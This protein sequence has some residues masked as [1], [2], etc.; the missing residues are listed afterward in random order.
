MPDDES[1]GSRLEV[2]GVQ[3][4]DAAK[5]LV[6]SFAAVGAA[7]I[8]GSQLSNIGRLPLCSSWTGE[9]ARLWIAVAG[10]LLALGGVVLAI[11]TGVSLLAPDHKQAADLVAEWQDGTVV[12]TYFERNPAQLQ[13]FDDFSDLIKRETTAYAEFDELNAAEQPDANAL[14]AAEIRLKDVLGR[15]DDAISIANHVIYVHHFKHVALRS[16]LAGAL[17][18]ALGIVAFSWASNPSPAQATVSLRGANL[19]G[20]SFVGTKLRSVDFTN[21]TLTDADFTEA[22]LL[23]A[24]LDDAAID[25]VTWSNTICPDGTNSDDAASSCENHL[26]P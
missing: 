14:G 7:L 22:D 12:R 25:G 17:V 18:A 19:S 4:R 23:G 20:A 5:W 26:T 3:I 21:A 24:A 10:A 1:I 13:G 15:G 6:A 8:A 2:Q 16:L 11:W 9:C